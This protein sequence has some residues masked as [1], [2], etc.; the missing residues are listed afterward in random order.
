MGDLSTTVLIAAGCLALALPLL[1]WSFTARPGAARERAVA[2]LGRDLPGAVVS[3]AAITVEGG[4]L[5]N[6]ARRL[7]PAAAISWLDTLLSRAGRP[8][9]WPLER[10]LVS[11]VVLSTAAVGFAL[12]VVASSPSLRG[13]VLAAGFVTLAWFVPD[14]LL[15]NHGQKRR[16]AIQLGLPDIL[17]QLTIAVG[18]GLGF[19]SAM[20]H[21]ARNSSGPLAEELIRTLQ[22][23]QVGAP[24]RLAYQALAD[25]TQV[26]DLRRFVRAI[27]QAEKHGVSISRVLNAQA[28]EMRMKRRQ[29]AEEKAMQIPVK[30]IFPLILFILPVLFIVVMGPGVI[31]IME[32]FSGQ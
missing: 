29:R 9:A 23:I 24:R 20:N 19:E 1:I 18:A 7:T 6:V 28:G 11:K 30:V 27:I 3:D 10:I 16:A 17:D 32:A 15:Y 13:A 4:G 31:G 25:R 8:A 2:N 26:Q 21:V 22:D 5:V 14:I 12:L